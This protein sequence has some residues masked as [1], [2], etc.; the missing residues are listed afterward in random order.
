M[1]SET[2]TNHSAAINAANSL[3]QV[4]TTR[5]EIQ[6][7][8]FRSALPPGSHTAPLL[9]D[10]FNSS[11]GLIYSSSGPTLSLCSYLKP[12]TSP[13]LLLQAPSLSLFPSLS[14]CRSSQTFKGEESGEHCQTDFTGSVP[15]HGNTK[16]AGG[17]EEDERWLYFWTKPHGQVN[18]LFH[19]LVCRGL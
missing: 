18:F 11:H 10:W 1:L 6:Q 17:T 3:A 13:S 9:P 16:I 14:L 4:I 8:W 15:F 19:K 12:W 2:L 5:A 7:P